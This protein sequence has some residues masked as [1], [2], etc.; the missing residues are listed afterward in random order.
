MT[1]CK[2]FRMYASVQTRC[3]CKVVE[4]S[5]DKLFLFHLCLLWVEGPLY[6]LKVRN[7][8]IESLNVRT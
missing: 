3:L 7:L 4:H 5:K 1:E 6:R 8:K 2:Y